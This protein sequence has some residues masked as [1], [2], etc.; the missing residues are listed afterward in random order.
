[1]DLWYAT[2]DQAANCWNEPIP[3]QLRTLVGLL[4]LF[5]LQQLVLS[6]LGLQ[7]APRYWSIDFHWFAWH[8]SWAWASNCEESLW[9]RRFLWLRWPGCQ[10]P[11][12]CQPFLPLP[13][14]IH[15]GCLNASTCC[16]NLG[17]CRAC[18]QL[19]L[20]ASTFKEFR[21]RAHLSS[22]SYRP[23]GRDY[24]LR[25]CTSFCFTLGCWGVREAFGRR[26]SFWDS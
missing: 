17:L 23:N 12:A 15:H 25:N 20:V 2:P 21:A 3:W 19:H 5:S 10:R 1:M 9:G 4:G 8:S 13:S 18:V 11:A 7:L 24:F 22:N 6:P 14:W 16:A 26:G